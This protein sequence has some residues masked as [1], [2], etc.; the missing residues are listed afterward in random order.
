MVTER[1]PSLIV[2]CG[3]NDKLP[4][5]EKYQVVGHRVN[6]E[7][8]FRTEVARLRSTIENFQI[9]GNSISLAGIGSCGL[10]TVAA[11]IEND[12]WHPSI[13]EENATKVV[14]FG[15]RF[16]ANRVDPFLGGR[17]EN[18]GI[19]WLNEKNDRLEPLKKKVTPVLWQGNIFMN[20]NE[21]ILEGTNEPIDLK[22]QSSGDILG[23]SVILKGSLDTFFK[24]GEETSDQL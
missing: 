2:V 9:R 23:A 19:A 10:V 5:S 3:P 7:N 14:T 16:H 6:S 22:R 11:F 8:S 13:D 24:D 18:E 12:I 1:K 4:Q 20:D 17:F 15:T 21:G